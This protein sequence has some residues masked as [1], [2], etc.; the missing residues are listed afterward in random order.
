MNRLPAHWHALEVD[1]SSAI[2]E[3]VATANRVPDNAWNRPLGPG[4]WTPAE[5]AGHLTESYRTLG[6]EL[7]GGPGMALKFSRLHRW[8]FRHTILRRILA[9]GRFPPGARAPRE[10]R[11]REMVSQAALGAL[12]AQAHGFAGELTSR[13]ADKRVRLTHAYFGPTSAADTMRLLAAHA[14]HHARQL[15]QA[16]CER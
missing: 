4:K 9:T 11:P 7:A 6:S 3:F 5:V 10:T 12:S 16:T 1:H 13:A 14:R 15:Q 8:V 2:A